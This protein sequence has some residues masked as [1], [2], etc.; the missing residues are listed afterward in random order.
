MF[1]IS[2]GEVCKFKGAVLY[3]FRVKP[4]VRREIDILNKNAIEQV[5]DFVYRK[6]CVNI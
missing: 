3:K 4:A 2:C 5:A 6:G 1:F